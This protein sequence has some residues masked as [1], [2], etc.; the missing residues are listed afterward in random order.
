MQTQER[1]VQP[2]GKH[3]C[4]R[5]VEVGCLSRNKRSKKNEAANG[6]PAHGFLNA[7]FRPI[8]AIRLNP[9]FSRKNYDFLYRSARNYLELSGSSFDLKRQEKDFTGLFRHLEGLLPQGQRLLLTEENKRLSFKIF[10]GDDFLCGE[11][12]FIPIEILNRTEGMFRDILL[13]F[14]QLFHQAHHF[15]AKED[16]YD[17][18]MIMENYF[19][20][21][22]ELDD[23]DPKVRALL[24][25]YREG[26]INDTFSLVCQ[27]PCRSTGELEQLLANYRTK[28]ER[29]KRLIASIRHGINIIR[30]NENIFRYVC[31]PG[32]NDGNFHVTG[33]EYIIEAERMIRFVYSGSDHISGSLLECINTESYDSA[34][35]YF[36]R[37]SLV[38]TPETDHLLEVDFVECFF[39][40]LTGFI[41]ALYDYE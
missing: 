4:K 32:E 39:T 2:P 34:N 29:E 37:R 17:Y 13:G 25:A 5:T 40:W 30:M 15:P 22:C 7:V 1:V 3:S 31:R 6:R 18:E 36:P 26:Y 12:F 41:N 33:D 8:P 9:L 14:F 20:E 19:E 23:D 35:E 27:K 21:W 10:F 11:V 24:E 38:L 28:D 16:L